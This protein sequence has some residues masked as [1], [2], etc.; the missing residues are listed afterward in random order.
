MPRE[1]KERIKDRM[2]KTAARLWGYADVEVESSFDPIVK[3]MLD[4]CSYELEK[5]SGDMEASHSR[6]IEKMVEVILPDVLVGIRPA[7]TIINALPVDAE[8]TLH[9]K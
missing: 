4:A 6:M 1:S 7:S 9:P 2:L 8:Y 3:L 5:I